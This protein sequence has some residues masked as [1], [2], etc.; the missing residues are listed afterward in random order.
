MVGKGI[1]IERPTPFDLYFYPHKGSFDYTIGA[2]HPNIRAIEGTF[3]VWT[4]HFVESTNTTYMEVLI[5]GN[6]Q[7]KV[8]LPVLNKARAFGGAFTIGR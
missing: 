4:D 7:N 8:E 6:P 1:T 5:D 3:Y 2:L